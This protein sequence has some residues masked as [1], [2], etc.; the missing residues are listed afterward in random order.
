MLFRVT[1]DCPKFLPQCLNRFHDQNARIW[2]KSAGECPA[3]IR[4]A[5]KHRCQALPPVE[6][7]RRVLLIAACLEL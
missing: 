6:Q 7:S 3:E 4:N 1:E 5:T 2:A